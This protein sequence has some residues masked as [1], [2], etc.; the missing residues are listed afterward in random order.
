M[1]QQPSPAEAGHQ[2]AQGRWWQRPL[3]NVF[4][5]AVTIGGLIFV[6]LQFDLATIGRALSAVATLNGLA[7]LAFSLALIGGSLVVRAYRWFIIVRGVGADVRFGRLVELYVVGNFF[8]AVLPSGFGG[9]IVR[10]VEMTQEMPAG[11]AT[12]TVI[13]DRLTGLLALFA[14]ALGV[15]PFR[16]A[17]FPMELLVVVALIC[18][19]GLAGGLTLLHPTTAGFLLRRLPRALPKSARTFLDNLLQVIA[20]CGSQR[21]MVALAISVV[22]NLMLVGWWAAAA[23][24]L[25]FAIPFGYLLLVIPILSIV[26]LIPSIGG[27]GVREALAPALL[28]AVPLSSEQAIALSLLVFALERAASLLG[29]PVYL[30]AMWRDGRHMTTRSS[31]L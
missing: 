15:L 13:M 26:L 2:Q 25:G 17:G 5:I 1:T 9:D 22:F 30:Y 18:G 7:W 3:V 27:L 10:V 19:V 16:P 23:R 21:V 14:M 11:V 29:G 28:A 6:I 31:Q 4:K 8:N 20:G 24:A 12:G